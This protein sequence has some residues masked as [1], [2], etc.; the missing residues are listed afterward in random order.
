MNNEHRMKIEVYIEGD[1]VVLKHGAQSFSLNLSSS[2]VLAQE[3]IEANQLLE[4]LETAKQ[5]KIGDLEK[6]IQELISEDSADRVQHHI[7]KW[8]EGILHSASADVLAQCFSVNS[9]GW[10]LPKATLSP[11][12]QLGFLFAMATHESDDVLSELWDWGAFDEL[13][14]GSTG[15]VNPRDLPQCFQPRLMPFLSQE[16]FIPKGRFFM[17]NEGMDALPC[18]YP[19]HTVELTQDFYLSRFPITQLQYFLFTEKN[20]SHFVG[21]LR[22]VDSISWFDAIRACNLYS[23]M[24]GLDCAYHVDGDQVF[25]N[26]ESNGYRLP[27]EAEWE[28]AARAFEEFE[29]SGSSQPHAVAWF[30]ENARSM[31]HRVGQKK[32]NAAHLYDMTGNVWEWVFDA[33]DDEIY[34]NGSRQDPVVEEGEYRVCRGGGYTSSIESLRITLRG[35]YEPEI[36]SEALGFRMARNAPASL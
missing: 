30:A 9:D 24:M 35:A 6:R 27:T 17:G 8:N 2:Q 14:Y 13:L 22:P 28:Y 15:V 31:T 23:E 5:T 3:L 29:F 34:M 16:C 11:L 36:K 12:G 21:A 32:P 1:Q 7:Q 4:Q 25:W 18:E 19:K 33:Y 26:R 20:P 10:A